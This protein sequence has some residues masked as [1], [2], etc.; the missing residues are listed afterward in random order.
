MG[1][2]SDRVCPE[3]PQFGAGRPHRLERVTEGV[4]CPNCQRWWQDEASVPVGR[5]ER[6]RAAQVGRKVMCNGY[7]G[8]ITRVCEWTTGMVEVRLAS[9]DVCVDVADVAP[10]LE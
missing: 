5:F 9:G 8:T 4:K 7:P 10:I 2:Q 3:C 6:E 1:K